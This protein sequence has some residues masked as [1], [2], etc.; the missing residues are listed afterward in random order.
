MTVT[1]VRQGSLPK[2]AL[3][4]EE[5]TKRM[6]CNREARDGDDGTATSATRTLLTEMRSWAGW[7]GPVVAV[8]RGGRA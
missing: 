5:M 4:L 6:Y 8:A 7:D 3:F 1:D 2:I